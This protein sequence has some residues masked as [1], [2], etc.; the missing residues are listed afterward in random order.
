[1]FPAIVHRGPHSYGWMSW[2]GGDEVEVAKFVGRSDTQQAVNSMDVEA[3]A[4]W[5]VG[6]VRY[7][8]HGKPT[9]L[10]NN[11]PI[12]HGNIVGVHNGIIRNYR[13]I[14]AETGREDETAKVDSE[15]IFAAVNSEGAKRGLAKV[16]GDMV[17]VFTNLKYPGTLNIARSYGRPLVFARTKAGSLI[18]ASEP[19]VIDT[20]EVPHG[21]FRNFISKNKLLKVRKGIIKERI[22]YRKVEAYVPPPVSC[23]PNRFI[24]P[25]LSLALANRK[26]D[27]DQVLWNGLTEEQANL[28]AQQEEDFYTGL[29]STDD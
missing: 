26:A 4:K 5:W 21:E 8:T 18:F 16:E 15:A 13:E 1:M 17:S 11:H 22:T 25:R 20:T 14:L 23:R 2:D 10:V 6:H 28:L 19:K 27:G 12:L 24:P 7:A 9:I 29:F 3:K